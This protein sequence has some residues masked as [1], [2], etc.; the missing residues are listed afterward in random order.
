[1]VL[2]VLMVNED[3]ERTMLRVEF[4]EEQEFFL[5]HRPA[6]EITRWETSNAFL[7]YQPS[8]KGPPEDV[9][10]IFQGLPIGYAGELEHGD[11]TYMVRI[12]PVESG[13]LY[14]AKNITHFEDREKLFEGALAVIV[15]IVL[16]LSLLLAVFN[17]RRIVKP[18]QGLAESIQSIPVGQKMPRLA[19]DYQDSELRSIAEAFNVFL[20]ELEAFVKREHTLLSLASHELRTPIAVVSGALDIVEQR[21]QLNEA[22]RATIARIRR[23]TSEMDANVN[24]L[25]KLARRETSPEAKQAVALVT[26]V[27][28]AMD[29]LSSDYQVKTRVTLQATAPINVYADPVMVKMLLRN[30]IQNALQHTLKRITVRLTPG[31]IEIIDEGEG[32]TAEQQSIIADRKKP[33]TDNAPVGGLGLYLVALISERLDWGLHIAESGPKGTVIQI[34]T[35]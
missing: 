12:S 3:L 34:H 21:N 9:P 11:Q 29:D 6:D 19:L 27:Q 5:A 33:F 22:D 20:G 1:M 2:T 15:L 18:L 24:I 13:H 8:E 4:V 10:K 30:V 32:L 14:I 25:L 17:S 35:G 26:V 28:Q 31:L 7:L 16:G 23:A